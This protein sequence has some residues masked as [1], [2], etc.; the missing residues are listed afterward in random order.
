MIRKLI[1]GVSRMWTK[2][3]LGCS[4][5]PEIEMDKVYDPRKEVIIRIAKD[6]SYYSV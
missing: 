4:Y 2:G 5:G 6:S 3:K 1:K